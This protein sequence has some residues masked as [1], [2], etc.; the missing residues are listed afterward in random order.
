MTSTDG[1]K[2]SLL[3]SL[4]SFPGDNSLDVDDDDNL[5]S[6]AFESQEASDNPDANLFPTD[7]ASTGDRLLSSSGLLSADGIPGAAA[8]G[9][10]GLFDQLEE[11]EKEEEE[12]AVIAE[13]QRKQLEK[14][15]QNR[16][17]QRE[18]QLQ[19]ER[20]AVL[21][22]QET[23]RLEAQMQAQAHAHLQDSYT[24]DNMQELNL[25]DEPGYR[26]P[27]HPHQ[28]N[29]ES[30][31]NSAPVYSNVVNIQNQSQY[32]MQGHGHGHGHGSVEQAP[33]PKQMQAPQPQ[34]LQ[35]QREQTREA[36]YGG[37]SYYYSTAGNVQQVYQQPNAN[38]SGMQ[39]NQPTPQQMQMQMDNRSQVQPNQ[40]RMPRNPPPQPPSNGSYALRSQMRQ[41]T[42]VTSVSNNQNHI[43]PHHQPASLLS[44][45]TVGG[46]STQGYPHEQNQNGSI[47]PGVNHHSM[48][49]P[50][51]SP[52][53]GMMPS[54]IRLG[55]P[56]LPPVPPYDPDSFV[57]VYGPISVTDPILVQSP[58]VFAGPP[59]W[60]YSVVVR[61]VKKIEGQDEFSAVVSSVRR[62]FRHF[63]ALEERMRGDSLG[64]ILPPRPDK[65]TTRAIDEAST[66]Q[67]AQ[68]A[69][70]RAQEL[71]TYLNA[72]RL[73]PIAGKSSVLQL[74][75]TL[76]DH[77]G[78]A[79][80]E[81]SSSLFTR[82]T[83]A[84]AGAA[85]KVAEGTSAVIAELNN[86]NQIMAGEDN[87][88]LLALA[89]SEG[90]RISSVLQAVPKIE[91]AI[92]LIAEQ[93][94][95]MS[96]NGLETQKLV[97][98]V[99]AHEKQ[100][101]VPFEVLSSGLL[102]SGRR[103]S[104]L[105]MELSAASHAF[106]MQ[107]KLC[108][109]ERLAFSDRRSSLVRR[110]DAR[111]EAD[112]K[113]QKLVM[114][115]HSLHSMGKIGQIAGYG[116]EATMSDEIAVEA[117]REAEQIGNILQGEVGRIAK[118]RQKDWSSSLRIMASSLREAHAERAAVWESCKDAFTNNDFNQSDFSSNVGENNNIVN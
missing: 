81:V 114:H 28:Q 12:R 43:H 100:F 102:R 40:M 27:P 74:F 6:L 47:A 19:D 59:H 86:E 26:N 104:R 112:Q 4:T 88:E 46:T 45:S 1:N 118:F 73:H 14:E 17:I 106:T 33:Q 3:S 8:G 2:F 16:R 65:Y 22:N 80:P 18:K 30:V 87:S 29:V 41:V 83:E 56:Q 63:V 34:P 58:G 92:A 67:S 10:A 32:N 76:P 89:S 5:P 79:W 116:R 11:E 49:I 108:R 64:A 25:N 113:A 109:Y 72:L 85:V 110:R 61:D 20:R 105:A 66:R 54:D 68:F 38:T 37:G 52:N 9:S 51:G 115:Q 53:A 95:R 31:P 50:V 78:V 77:L 60:T 90:L 82:L 42:N 93:G 75:L 71:Q 44:S 48:T 84:G 99:M 24:L 111:K 96:V 36:G 70:Q 97:N 62:R 35:V 13:E 98:N 103:T 23:A 15:E 107:H 101:A 94:D 21:E 91:H 7:K 57:P 117:V 55:Q 39:G 69:L